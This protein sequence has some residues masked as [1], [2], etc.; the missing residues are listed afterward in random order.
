MMIM[1]ETRDRILFA[2]A[3]VCAVLLCVNFYKI[4]MILPDEANQGAIPY[5]IV[6]VHVPSIFT[7]FTGFFVAL[8]ASGAPSPPPAN[9]STT[10]SPPPSPKSR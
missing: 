5:R 2:L 10:P 4:F 8:A 6:Y 7:G 9:S 1:I 3:A